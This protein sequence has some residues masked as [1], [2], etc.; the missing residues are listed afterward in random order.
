T[1]NKIGIGRC[2]N[3]ISFVHVLENAS[4]R[5]ACRF[6]VFDVTYRGNSFV[7]DDAN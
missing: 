5:W 1:L 3:R 4:I 7:V 6:F 2:T